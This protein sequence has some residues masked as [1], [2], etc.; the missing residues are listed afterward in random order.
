MQ[1]I[2]KAL[3]WTIVA[4]ESTHVFCCVLPTLVSV[5]SLIAGMSALSFLPGFIL[6]IHETLHAYEVPTIAFSG[7]MLAV[8]WGLHNYS[9]KL[10]CADDSC[11][12]HESCAPK[13]DHTFM[14]MV[15]A[16]VLFAF[17]ILVYFTFHYGRAHF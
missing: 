11:C 14:I 2:Q 17:N 4:S 6:E 5:I 15:G 8:G 3:F 9:R 16:T 7:L 13:K 10:D 1:K 12:A